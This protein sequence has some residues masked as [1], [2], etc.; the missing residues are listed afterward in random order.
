MEA[1]V[2]DLP[3]PVTPVTSTS[4]RVSSASLSTTRGRRK[5][6]KEGTSGGMTR[7]TMP[8][9]PFCWKTLTRKRM[10]SGVA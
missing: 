10:P 2:V 9:S 3:L 5:E 7:R 6:S 8:G 1:R 4:P